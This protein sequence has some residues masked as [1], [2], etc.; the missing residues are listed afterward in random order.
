MTAGLGQGLKTDGRTAQPPEWR[1]AGRM[2]KRRMRYGVFLA[3][4]PEKARQAGA[5]AG[6][7]RPG[8]R[9]CPV[10]AAGARKP[11]GKTQ[12]RAAASCS[13]GGRG[14]SD[15]RDGKEF[16][17]L[18]RFVNTLF[19]LPS[20]RLRRVARP[21][22]A[23]MPGAPDWPAC[24]RGAVSCRADHGHRCPGGALRLPSSVN[25]VFRTRLS[26][27]PTPGSTGT[28]RAASRPDPLLPGSTRPALRS[29]RPLSL[30]GV[31]HAADG[32]KE[33]TPA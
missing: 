5:M 9:L 8:C 2:P 20:S 30:P 31:G 23:Q 18:C 26:G 16:H 21:R 11:C 19:V 14:A 4:V 7:V 10:R 12:Q 33:R 32:D 3:D 25:P 15:L 17:R 29:P 27:I 28:Q 24:V 1:P 22:P 6:S 13:C